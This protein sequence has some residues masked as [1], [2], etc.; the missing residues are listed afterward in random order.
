VGLDSTVGGASAN[1]YCTVAEADGY[2][3]TRDYNPEWTNAD[4]P[5]K[6]KYLQWA[7]RLL[8]LSFVFIGTRASSLQSLMW[9]RFDA[10]DRDGYP[11]LSNTVP[12]LL[13]NAEAEFAFQLMKED[14][15]QGLTS[16][17]DQGIQ[18]GSLR[19]TPESHNQ[20]PASVATLISPLVSGGAGA[21]RAL[22]MV[23]G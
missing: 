21:V 1:S 13:K 20:I 6:E 23:L 19:T 22:D 10:W 7:T 3:A 4:T 9:P 14:W 11:Y 5:T 16:V 2:H 17:T 15:T 12:T 18:L 8:D